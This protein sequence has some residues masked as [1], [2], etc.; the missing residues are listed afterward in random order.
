MATT[1]C[2]TSRTGLSQFRRNQGFPFSRAAIVALA[3]LAVA[4]G[5]AW[6]DPVL[7]Q[8]AEPSMLL[9]GA[10]VR[11]VASGLVTPIGV[12]SIDTNS[13]FVIEKSTG[14]VQ[15]IVDG[16]LRGTALDLA[17]NSAS[18]RGLLG[19]ALD[20]SFALNGY[21]YLY[22]TCRT[23]GPQDLL[24]P[25]RECPD[26][27]E[28][29][30]DTADVLSVPLLG[31]RVD[32]FVWD[33]TALTFERNLIKLRAFQADGAPVPAGQGDETQNP[34]GNHNGGVI[35]IGPDGKL[36]IVIGDNGRRGAMQNLPFGPKAAQEA[37]AVQDD[38]FGGPDPDDAHFTGV[39]I[40]LNTDGTIPIDNPFYQAGS[41]MGGEA[42]ANVQRTYAYG[43]RNS[44]GMAFDPISGDLWMSE[45]G[46][47]S[48][49]ELNR[50]AP[51][52]N[53]GW[54]QMMGPSDRVADFKQTETNPEFF[55]LQQLRYPPTNTSDS[56]GEAIAKLLELPGSHFSEP[57]FSWRFATAPAAIGF[58]AGSGFG[59]RS[60]GDLIVGFS[61][62]VA[63]GGALV[64]FELTAGRDAI[65]P[66][67]AALADGV[68]DNAGK[69][70][71]TESGGLVIG[72]DFG[73]VTDIQNGRNGN[74]LV[75]SLSK[76]AV[77]EVFRVRP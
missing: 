44:F 35:R 26:T 41:A 69:H 8:T 38:Q 66:A 13:M 46:D 62:P 72:R 4:A 76:G 75:V 30:A 1:G 31:N 5:P 48:Y 68:D 55:G 59:N 65:A 37:P 60:R 18:E 74:V 54:I 40:R 36:Y 3:F 6:R 42:G 51:G 61:V 9:R 77:Y 50:V 52:F 16:V 25:L 11:R 58:I 17:V 67:S 27:P 33:G 47:D 57:E 23:A 28:L 24:N 56:R 32:R 63:F 34:A 19:I 43:I 49:D 53:S 39:I 45:N 15:H 22:W 10:G 71:M 29:G 2:P 73:V 20:R 21:V 64:R 12:A 70:E 14:K 7:A